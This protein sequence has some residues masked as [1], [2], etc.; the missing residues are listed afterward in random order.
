VT[1]WQI[2][3]ILFVCS[4]AA[5][6]LGALVRSRLPAHHV[7][8]DSRDVMKLVMGLIATMAALVLG[9][10]I[11]SSKAS[12]DTQRQDM[13]EVAASVVELD[14]LLAHYGPETKAAREEMYRVVAGTTAMLASGSGATALRQNPSAGRAPSYDVL[15]QVQELT[16]TNDGQRFLQNRALSLAAS[17]RHLQD[18]MLE[19]LEAGLPWPFVVVVVFWISLLFMGFGLFAR[20]HATLAVGLAVGALSV[21]SAM[22]LIL[23]LSSPYEGLMRIPP[24]TFEAVLSQINR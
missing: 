23:E 6:M 5:A 16:P 12:Y 13:Q 10:L 24:D 8:S 18:L 22:F 14:R 4:Y 15:T 3:G 7:D 21:A 11:A 2:S 1:A 17:I 9:L 20:M 19:Q